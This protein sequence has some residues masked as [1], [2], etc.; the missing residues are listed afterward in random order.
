[1]DPTINTTLS[2]VTEKKNKIWSQISVQF[3]L[4]GE[5]TCIILHNSSLL[6]RGKIMPQ[7]VFL[8][9]DVT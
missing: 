5:L 8:S 7:H 3:L 1:M 9:V 6:F 2:L 4:E